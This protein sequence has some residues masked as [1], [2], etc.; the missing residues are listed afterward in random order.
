MSLSVDDLSVIEDYGNWW[1]S[2]A[3]YTMPVQFFKN[4]FA[5]IVLTDIECRELIDHCDMIGW[6]SRYT[7]GAGSRYAHPSKGLDVIKRVKEF[8][9]EANKQT[10]NYDID[11]DFECIVNKFQSGMG[12]YFHKDCNA[13]RPYCKLSVSVLLSDPK[14]FAG[15]EFAFFEQGTPD[16]SHII[17]KERGAIV[18]FPA[19]NEHKVNIITSGTRL[20]LCLFFYG[21]KFR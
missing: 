6:H 10:F 20:A 12:Y 19:F 14:D 11:D 15:G 13:H 3:N 5:D 4:E 17:T 9:L 1:G 21:P 2:C 7:L 16:N 8:V 18:M